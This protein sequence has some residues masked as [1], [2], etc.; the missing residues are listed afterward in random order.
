M[1]KCHFNQKDIQK[2]T[3]QKQRQLL[4]CQGHR[5]EDILSNI[6]TCPNPLPVWQ[7]AKKEGDDV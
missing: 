7:R 1:I 3:G 4:S 5:K 6:P 2:T